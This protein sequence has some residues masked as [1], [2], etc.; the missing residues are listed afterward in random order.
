MNIARD[1]PAAIR[2]QLRV[3]SAFGCANC[4]N[5][6][7]EY[8]HIAPWS[9]V[10]QHDPA[11]MIALCPNCH[12][13]LGKLP[14]ERCYKL[15][16][17]PYNVRHGYVKGRVYTDNSGEVEEFGGNYAPRARCFVRFLG[18]PMLSVSYQNGIAELSMTVLDSSC[19]PI[20]VIEKNDV[21]ARASALTDFD[22]RTNYL[23]IKAPTNFTRIELDFRRR[24][25]SI[26]GKIGVGFG[27][28]VSFNHERIRLGEKQGTLSKC[29]VHESNGLFTIIHPEM[30][31]MIPPQNLASFEEFTFVDAAGRRLGA[32]EA[33]VIAG[34][35]PQ[36]AVAFGG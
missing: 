4:G 30:L 33:A 36:F 1:I 15:K 7:L 2:R 9:V 6:L 10:Q 13:T 21:L 3:E 19:A 24:P 31:A 28:Y 29:V 5:P 14:R 17:D 27:A 20:L 22:F 8:H 18:H 11:E 35:P 12:T 25:A 32:S 23:L 26:L 16:N 34:D